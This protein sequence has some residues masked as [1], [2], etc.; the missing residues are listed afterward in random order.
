[1]DLISLSCFTCDGRPRE[2]G[3]HSGNKV[4]SHAHEYEQGHVQTG[5]HARESSNLQLELSKDT[6]DLSVGRMF[7]QPRTLTK[8]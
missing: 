3:H 2:K 1:M 6:A 8:H 5:R 7:A 4:F